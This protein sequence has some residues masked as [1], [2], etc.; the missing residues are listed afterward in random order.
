MKVRNIM[1]K[2]RKGLGKENSEQGTCLICFLPQFHLQHFIWSP[3]LAEET[4]KHRARI[5]LEHHQA[6]PQDQK[7]FLKLQNFKD[8]L[9]MSWMKALLCSML[10]LNE[11][12]ISLLEDGIF[13]RTV[14]S[15]C[16]GVHIFCP[17]NCL[18]CPCIH[19]TVSIMQE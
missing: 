18:L 13:E 5:S 2:D 11:E 6:W 15:F 17:D 16:L 8:M 12:I 4:Y 19:I 1:N 10:N 14:K 3:T 7:Y 9:I